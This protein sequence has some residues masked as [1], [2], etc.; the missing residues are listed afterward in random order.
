MKVSTL[1]VST[2]RV[3]QGNRQSWLKFPD[4]N[5]RFKLFLAL[6]NFLSSLVAQGL[7]DDEFCRRRL[8]TSGA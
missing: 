5:L 1:K 6:I 2:L 8:S 3:F 4:P 7:V